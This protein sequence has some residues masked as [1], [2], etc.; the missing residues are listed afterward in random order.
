VREDP[1]LRKDTKLW[2]KFKTF[3]FGEAEFCEILLKDANISMTAFQPVWQ[4][5]SMRS[6]GINGEELITQMS[7][8]EEGMSNVYLK[9]AKL[10]YGSN[11]R[12]ADAFA[13]VSLCFFSRG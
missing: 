12:F 13:R 1:R 4:L 2:R 8:I 10:W 11:E 6:G 5:T 7:L 3:F 9:I